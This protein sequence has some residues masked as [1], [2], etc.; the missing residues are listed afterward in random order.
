MTKAELR[1]A[2]VKLRGDMRTMIEPTPTQVATNERV[3][4]KDGQVAVAAWY[5]QMGGYCGRCW[6]VFYPGDEK[7]GEHCFDV[8][9]WHDGEFPF[10]DHAPVELHHCNPAQ[11]IQFGELARDV[12]RIG[13]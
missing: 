3:V 6:I 12:Q 13:A 11:F 9:V 4:L 5:P 10:G 1:A 8:F 2:C 7:P